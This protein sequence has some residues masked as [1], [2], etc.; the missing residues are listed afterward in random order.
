MERRRGGGHGEWSWERQL[1]KARVDTLG[2][3]EMFSGQ[4]QGGQGGNAEGGML[5]FVWGGV[6]GSVLEALERENE[7]RMNTPRR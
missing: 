3:V 1:T 2:D 5:T 4:G 7:E 6:E